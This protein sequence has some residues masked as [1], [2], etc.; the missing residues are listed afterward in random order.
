MLAAPIT[1]AI[2][3]DVSGASSDD[4]L[5]ALWLATRGSPRTR[6]EYAHDARLLRA[7]LE[8]HGSTLAT[9]TVSTFQSWIEGL[10]GAPASRARR[11][12]AAKSLLR[13]GKQTGYLQHDIGSVVKVPAQR[14]DLAAR[15]LEE[16]E[17]AMLLYSARGHLRPLLR[18]L[19]ASGAR[20]SEALGLRWRDVHASPDGSA[21]LS[22]LGKGQRLRHVRLE[23][24]TV[25]ELGPR[26]EPDAYL[27][28]TSTGAPV[29]ARYACA[30]LHDLS[31]RVLGKRVSPHWLRHAHASHALDRGAPTHLVQTTLGH[32]SLATTGRYAH[33]RPGLS[34]GSYLPLPAHVSRSA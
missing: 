18:L 23:A 3:P 21:V 31:L 8:E 12:S 26:R 25:R 28:A 29:T 1:I 33:A 30:R 6:T 32:A 10:Q 22:I 2:A 27:F 4:E 9:M 20:I 5:V 15:I 16:G 24:V 7:H 17:V 11:I 14:Q 34:S 13:F 19:Y